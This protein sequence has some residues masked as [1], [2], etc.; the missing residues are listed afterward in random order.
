MASVN[1]VVKETKRSIKKFKGEVAGAERLTY[2]LE[3]MGVPVAE[4]KAR[5]SELKDQAKRMDKAIKNDEKYYG[6]NR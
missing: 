1:A 4:E 2:L 6:N 5:V 3:D